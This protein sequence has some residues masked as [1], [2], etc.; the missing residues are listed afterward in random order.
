[1]I[2]YRELR[3]IEKDLGFDAKTLYGLSNN[4]PAHYHKE[5]I[6]KSDGTKRELSVPDF[7]LKQVQKSIADNILAYYP[8]SRFAQGYAFGSSVRKNAMPHV[9]KKKVLKLDIE[10]F[11]DHIRYSK[12][13]DIVF[14][15]EKFSEQIRILLTMLCYYRDVL[16]QGAPSS[17]AITNIVMFDFDEKIGA[18][19]E[20]YGISY[21]RYCDDMTF[22]GDFDEKAVIELVKRELKKL[23]LFLKNRKTV[24]VPY[25]K[26][27]TVTGIVV[28]EK[29]NPARDYRKKIRMEIYCIQ[30]F[31]LGDHLTWIGETDKEKY[32]NCL[33][34][35]VAYVLQIVPRN[36]EFMKYKD[37]LKNVSNDRGI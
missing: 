37:F 22:S 3:S 27:Q 26:R 21:T 28:N 13:K 25:S 32:L 23:G 7:I 1:M 16:P 14:F 18:Y 12:V 33:K 10:G 5:F 34:G 31:G 20:K 24:I 11:F 8:V 30:K 2:V 35:R 19:C 17:P 36:K 6:P 15:K 9:G 4:I 29:V